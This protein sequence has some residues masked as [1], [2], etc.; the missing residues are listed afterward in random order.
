MLVP[1]SSPSALAE[2]QD[3]LKAQAPQDCFVHL[4]QSTL[5]MAVFLSNRY[6]QMYHWVLLVPHKTDIP[7]VSG[8][9]YEINVREQPLTGTS[10]RWRCAAR[11]SPA[12]S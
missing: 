3:Q 8:L 12:G 9:V 11:R 10:A 1:I 6:Q 4:Q 7:C 2:F 5:C